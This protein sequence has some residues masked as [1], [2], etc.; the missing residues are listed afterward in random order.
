MADDRADL[1]AGVEEAGMPTIG[2]RLVPIS[3]IKALL[4]KRRPLPASH[5]SV[6]LI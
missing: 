6:L 4:T 5:S 1:K 2:K 3:S